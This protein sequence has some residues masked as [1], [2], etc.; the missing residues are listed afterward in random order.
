M[1][2]DSQDGSSAGLTRMDLLFEIASTTS[3][4]VE[5][6]SSIALGACSATQCGQNH[7]RSSGGS[8]VSG[9]L[10]HSR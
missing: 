1:L 2:R 8:A 3:S 7:L 5:T 4:S 10:R 6:F 9:G